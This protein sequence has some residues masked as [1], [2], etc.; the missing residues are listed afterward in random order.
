VQLPADTNC[1]VELAAVH[2]VYTPKMY[3]DW[4]QGKS[5]VEE[6]S[7]FLAAVREQLTYGIIR[8]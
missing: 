6:N 7:W 5:A 2:V 4:L 8:L 1:V 3:S